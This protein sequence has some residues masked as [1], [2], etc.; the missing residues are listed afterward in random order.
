MA[1][2]ILS[3]IKSS[4]VEINGFGRLK[5][6]G[7]SFRERTQ[8]RFVAGVDSYGLTQCINSGVWLAGFKRDVGPLLGAY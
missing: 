7:Q 4:P 1:F 3:F 5:F 8:G 2:E 6:I